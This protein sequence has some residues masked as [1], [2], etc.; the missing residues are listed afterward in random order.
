MCVFVCVLHFQGL[1]VKSVPYPPFLRPTYLLPVSTAIVS[2]SCGIC[3]VLFRHFRLFSCFATF[4]DIIF[5]SWRTSLFLLSGNVQ[6]G[7]QGNFLKKSQLARLYL[8]LHKAGLVTGVL[9][10]TNSHHRI[11]V[12]GRVSLRV[13]FRN[14]S[15]TVPHVFLNFVSFLLHVVVR[16]RRDFASQLI[17]AADSL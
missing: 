12:Y 10:N 4:R 7:A 16:I 6:A 2:L 13:L 11:E 14:I 1:S 9:Y 8:L 17:N 15:L 5:N 3:G